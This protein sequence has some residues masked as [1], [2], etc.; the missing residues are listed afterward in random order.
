ME[1]KIVVPWK[2]QS[3]VWWNQTCANIIEVFGLPGNRYRTE[4]SAEAMVF[5]FN[6]DKD[7]FMCQM[8]V[9]EEI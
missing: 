2:S 3:D 5:Y 8:M 1:N 7:A 9:S 6:N 4:V